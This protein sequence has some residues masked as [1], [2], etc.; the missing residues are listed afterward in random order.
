MV[1]FSWMVLFFFSFFLPNKYLWGC[2]GYVSNFFS[3]RRFSMQGFAARIHWFIIFQ[4][5]CWY[6]FGSINASKKKHP[7]PPVLNSYNILGGG[8]IFFVFSHPYLGETIQFDDHIL[9]GGWCNHQLVSHGLICGGMGDHVTTANLRIGLE[10][11]QLTTLQA[12]RSAV[13]WLLAVIEDDMGY[14]SKLAYASNILL[15]FSKDSRKLLMRFMRHIHDN[16]YVWVS[17]PW[18]RARK[19]FLHDTHKRGDW[20]LSVAGSSHVGCDTRSDSCS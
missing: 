12:G 5:M 9:Q 18:N 4:V 11:L 13:D 19:R 16:T 20:V 10:I 6:H 8:L 15:K 3:F 1:S 7:D 14:V 17:L 2:F